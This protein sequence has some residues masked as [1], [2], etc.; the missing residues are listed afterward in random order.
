MSLVKIE[1]GVKGNM[2]ST[3][4]CTM[5]LVQSNLCVSLAMLPPAVWAELQ[6][7]TFTVQRN[8]KEEDGPKA[9]QPGCVE[10]DGWRI[11]KEPHSSSCRGHKA[12]QGP[13]DDANLGD[14]SSIY[15]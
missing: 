14:A 10:E 6:A 7:E 9:G 1:T 15:S 2:R 3:P 5:G 4:T 11:Q 12:G 8:S 13:T